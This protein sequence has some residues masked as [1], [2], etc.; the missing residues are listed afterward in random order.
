M[1]GKLIG[2]GILGVILFLVIWMASYVIGISNQDKSL[3]NL[4]TAKKSDQKQGHDLMWKKISQVAQ[5]TDAQ[6]NAL[7]EIF[8]GYASARTGTGDGGSMM[9]WV[10]ESCPNVDTSTFNNLMNVITSS[11]DAFAFTQRELIDLKRTHDN[12]LDLFPS[13]FVLSLLGR[14][15]VDITIVSSSRTEEVIKTG[16]DDDVS[17]FEKK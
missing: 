11:R 13:S 6:K 9:K 3:R 4:I 14:E 12:L 10:Q 5:V 15:K 2:F 7:M 1:S 17:V 8:N 16:K